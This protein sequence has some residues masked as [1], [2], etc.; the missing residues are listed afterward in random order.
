MK[1]GGPAL[2]EAR[3]WLK[4]SPVLVVIGAAVLV[5][6]AASGSLAMS[7]VISG[8]I[9]GI[10]TAILAIASWRWYRFWYSWLLWAVPF[11]AGC[12][13]LLEI[14]ATS[15]ILPVHTVLLHIVASVTLGFGL[16][17]WLARSWILRL[18]T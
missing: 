4:Q 7:L 2:I 17:I 9:V 13:T 18:L 6:V 8:L 14:F 5:A 10:L 1:R 12:A 3:H 16:S 11:A 15:G